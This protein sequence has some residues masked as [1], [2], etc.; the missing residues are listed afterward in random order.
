MGI[1]RNHETE[2]DGI[3]YKTTTLPASVG[4]SVMPRLVALLG[5]KILPLLFEVGGEGIEALFKDPK[6]IGTLI[7]NIADRAA[8][9]MSAG[10]DPMGVLR[11]LLLKTTADKVRVGSAEVEGSVY[12]SFDSHFAG[13]YRHLIAVVGWVGGVNFMPASTDE[14]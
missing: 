13:D 7:S 3:A 14:S 2:I 5:D 10:E 8:T 11:D 4:L 1:V 6:V 12:K 9:K